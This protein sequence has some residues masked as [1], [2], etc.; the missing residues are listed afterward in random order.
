MALTLRSREA[1]ANLSIEAR[2]AAMIDWARAMTAGE[3]RMPPARV[4]LD[5]PVPDPGKLFALLRPHALSDLGFSLYDWDV[6]SF[7]TVRAAGEHLARE[8]APA[9]MPSVPMGKLYDRDGWAW[10]TVERNFPPRLDRPAVFIL[11]APRSGSTLLRVM[12]AGHPELFAPPEL[13]LLPF[14]SMNRR[15]LMFEKLGYGWMRRGLISAIAELGG[16]TPQKAEAEVEALERGEAPVAEVFERLQERAQPRILVDKSPSYAMHPAWLGYAERTFQKPLYIHLVRH[17]AAAIESFVRMRFHRL[18]GR[19]W[20]VWDDNPWLYGEKCWTSANLQI[21]NFLSQVEPGR[22]IRVSYERLVSDPLAVTTRI[23][24]F[25]DIPF[26]PA[27]LSPYSGRR[28]TE[29][30]DGKG[31]AIGD[32]NFLTHGRIDPSLASRGIQA[33]SNRPLGQATRKIAS[34]LRYSI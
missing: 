6:P 4:D 10:G 20:L 12:L 27:L 16:L 7:T 17:P 3:L 33:H 25:L 21:M 31:A 9:P 13:H 14:D 11:S 26:D 1:L 24:K 19:H 30:F 23:C 8:L 34:L 32:P 15:R 29:D 18:L 2:H 22:Q 5:R 28:Y